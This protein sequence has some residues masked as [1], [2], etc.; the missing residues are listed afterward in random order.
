MWSVVLTIFSQ[1][2]F[3]SPDTS[4]FGPA[5]LLT[6]AWKTQR[7]LAGYSE[8]DAHEFLQFILDQ[9]HDTSDV[10]SLASA[11]YC[12]CLVHRAFRG[13]LESDIICPCCKNVT[14]TIDPLMDLSL[15]L[16]D[17]KDGSK[18]LSLQECLTKYICLTQPLTSF[19]TL[20]TIGLQA[21][22]NS[23]QS[24]TAPTAQHSRRSQS[25]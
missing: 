16:R 25:S 12:G 20:T 23:K 17:R 22:K 13:Q 18:L 19:M 11:Q 15:E 10:K 5:S 7:S 21:R 14:A 9:L 1:Q 3:A 8:Q 6:T 4:G 2:F 24:T